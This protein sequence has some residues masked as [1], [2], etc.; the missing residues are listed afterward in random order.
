MFFHVLVT[1][2]SPRTRHDPP[3]LSLPCPKILF[4]KV[5]GNW[6]YGSC[7]TEKIFECRFGFSLKQRDLIRSLNSPLYIFFPLDI[8]QLIFIIE[9]KKRNKTNG[10][11]SD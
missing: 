9:L 4:D 10:K 8:D 7:M 3:H 1:I 11:V 5:G 2:I 6:P